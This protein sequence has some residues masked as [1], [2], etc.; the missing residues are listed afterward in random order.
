MNNPL[1]YHEEELRVAQSV[2]DPRRIMPP[3]LPAGCTVLDIG[4]GAGQTLIAAFPDRLSFG[5][6]IDIAALKYGTTLTN[7][8]A[9]TCG[10]AESLPFSDESFDAVVARVSLPYTDLTR[11]LPEIYRSL[12]PGGTLWMTLHEFSIPLQQAKRGGLK[13]WIFFGYVLVN[14]L[15]FHCCQRL[16]ALPGRGYE[17][18]QTNYGIRRAL[19]KCGFEGVSIE[20]K[21]PQFLVRTIKPST[22]ASA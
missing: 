22:A 6:D 11:S 16:F 7:K 13:A 8:V 18:F 9:F 3:D 20:R 14:S 2:G 5:I 17:S 21:P 15:L 19:E 4:C 10:F 12:R 1:S